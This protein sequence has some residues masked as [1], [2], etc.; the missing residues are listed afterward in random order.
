MALVVCFRT[1]VFDVTRETP[2]SINAIA[3]QS[4]LTWLRDEL[5]R[6]QYEC[7][8]PDMEDWGWYIEVKSAGNSYLVG[9]STDVEYGDDDGSSPWYNVPPNTI[10]DW[11]L[12]VQKH[13]TV[14]EKLFR[15]NQMA[16]DDAF[17]ATIERIVRSD[18]RLEEISVLRDAD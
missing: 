7:T 17:C 3:G 9:A 4:V 11:T 8:L 12:Q 18:N 5:A 13:R 16:A 6:H 1:S 14:L 15:M 10:L 2:N